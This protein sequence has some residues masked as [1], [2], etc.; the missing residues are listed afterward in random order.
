[1]I[2]IGVGEFFAHR[3]GETFL[4][5]PS[6][7]EVQRTDGVEESESHGAADAYLKLDAGDQAKESHLHPFEKIM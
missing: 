4:N 6:L 5:Y 1:V 2:E 3:S 7:L